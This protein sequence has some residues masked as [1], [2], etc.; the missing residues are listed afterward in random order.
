M[1][2][3]KVLKEEIITAFNV[4]KKLGV[5]M[6]KKTIC[7]GCGCI[8]HFDALSFDLS[9]LDRKIKEVKTPKAD[10]VAWCYECKREHV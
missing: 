7:P 8:K 10:G 5:I 4:A 3:K 9:V 2:K 6:S 1:Q